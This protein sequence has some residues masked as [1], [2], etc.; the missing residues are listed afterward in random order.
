MVKRIIAIVV[1][2][3]V[4]SCESK[5]SRLQSFLLKGNTSFK[6]GDEE[7]ALYYYNEALKIDPC[8][9]DAFTNLGTVHH[10]AGRYD[11]AIG[12]YTKAIEC[13]P[14]YFNARMNRA[15]SYY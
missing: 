13:Q 9:V 15:N 1:V 4:L 5:E 10:N 8:F 11:E 6:E 3:S 7:R 14:A 2:L 12:S